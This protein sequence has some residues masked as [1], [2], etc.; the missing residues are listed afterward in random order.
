MAL[1]YFGE[2]G[3]DNMLKGA[4]GQV[5][6]DVS[7]RLQLLRSSVDEIQKTL[8]KLKPDSSGFKELTKILRPSRKNN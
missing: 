7:A 6:I 3:V 1:F 8:D 2:K 5:T 4:N